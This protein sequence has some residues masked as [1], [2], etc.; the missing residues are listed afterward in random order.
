[1]EAHFPMVLV[2]PLFS[3]MRGGNSIYTDPMVK[4]STYL[5]VIQTM[6][7]NTWD[8]VI[9]QRMTRNEVKKACQI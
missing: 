6:E 7:R 5:R 3:A 9:L 4:A 1:M 2:R 8:V